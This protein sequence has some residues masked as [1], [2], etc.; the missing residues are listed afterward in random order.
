MKTTY[1]FDPYALTPHDDGLSTVELDDVDIHNEDDVI[2]IF[3]N[4]ID[5]FQTVLELICT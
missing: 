5:P 3:R 4:S 1:G 2:T